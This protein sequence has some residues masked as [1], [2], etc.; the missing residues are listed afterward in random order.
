MF[1]SPEEVKEVKNIQAQEGKNEKK[2]NK[3]TYSCGS[4][5]FKCIAS[6]L[7]KCEPIIL[8]TYKEHA[9]IQIEHW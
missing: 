5:S 4:L 3:G 8:C 9:C 7:I 6:Q 2:Q 1:A